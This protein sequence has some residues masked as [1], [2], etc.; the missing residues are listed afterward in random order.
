MAL[1]A[2]K[3]TPADCE[4]SSFSANNFQR[5]QVQ[6]FK[7]LSPQLNDQTDSDSLI[8]TQIFHLLN[9]HHFLDK[10]QKHKNPTAGEFKT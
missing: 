6:L 5:F 3:E 8:N 1:Q 4:N 7:L 10:I 2:L 9:Q